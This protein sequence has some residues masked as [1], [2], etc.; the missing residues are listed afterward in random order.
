MSID[1][2]DVLETNE[3]FACVPLVSGKLLSCKSFIDEDYATAVRKIDNYP[4]DSF[5][6]DRYKHLVEKLNV[7]GGA[8]A[9]GHANTASGARIMITAAEELRRRGGGIAASVPH[10][11][12]LHREMP[13]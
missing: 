6:K 9:V 5:S 4:L 10:V 7:N 8:I 13:A 1:E 2:I 12:A 3:A 11:A